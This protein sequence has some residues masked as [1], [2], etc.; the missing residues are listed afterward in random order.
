MKRLLVVD[1]DPDIHNFINHDLKNSGYEIHSAESTEEAINLLGEYEFSFAI[2]DIFMGEN[3]SSN[4]VIHFLKQ[5]LAGENKNIPMIIMS[6]HIDDKY[7]RKILLKG[8]TVFET[9]QKPL[10]PG[11]II[12]LIE[13]KTFPSILALDDDPDILSLIKRELISGGYKVFGT[14]DNERA[15]KLIDSTSFVAAIVDNKLGD[16]Q[17]TQEICHYIEELPSEAQIPLILTGKRINQEVM[18]NKDLLVFDTIEKPFIRGA[19]LKSVQRISLWEENSNLSEEENPYAKVISSVTENSEEEFE[20]VSGSF[21]DDEAQMEIAGNGADEN[22]VTTVGGRTEE[23]DEVK[24][25]SG[26]DE[27]DRGIHLV[28]GYEEDD[29]ENITVNGSAEDLTEERTMIQGQKQIIEDEAWQVK[30]LKNTKAT[31]QGPNE[32]NK[33]GV[34]PVMAYC[35]TGDLEKVRELI[36]QGADLGLKARNG[37]T[38]L[39][40][41]AYSKNIEL[42][43]YLVTEFNLRINERDEQK[44]EPL[45]D[46]MKA[47]DPEMVDTFINLGARTSSKYEGRNYLSLAVMMRLPEVAKI[48]HKHG[49]SSKEK[50]YEGK[51]ALDYAQKY[52][53]KDLYKQIS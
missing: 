22:E 4:K 38:C 7:A 24:S 8:P 50:D 19:F 41:A 20:R 13:G 45:F 40:Y 44:R 42:V 28:G 5:D 10:R 39:H 2:V 25:I 14:L 15:K 16:G 1:D 52:G 27:E 35:Y 29:D 17:D 33:Q 51:S 31:P 30:S 6:A 18:N 34:T 32:R 36:E 49:L 11:Q 23:E 43:K 47:N 48:F 3:K 21:G 37:K 53:F 46:A 26:N 12:E 9:L